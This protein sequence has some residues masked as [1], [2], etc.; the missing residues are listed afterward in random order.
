MIRDPRI[1]HR[2]VGTQSNGNWVTLVEALRSHARRNPQKIACACGDQ[3]ITYE[4]LDDASTRLAARLLGQGL[5]PGDRLAIHWPN[6]IETVQLFFAAFKAGLI[7]VPVNLRLKTAEIEF[8]LKHSGATLC[9]SHPALSA[10][11]QP[12]AAACGCLLRT[13][14]PDEQ[15]E[16]ATLPHVNVDA[17][18]IILYTSGTTARPK[19]VVHTHETLLACSSLSAQALNYVQDDIMVTVLPMMHAAALACVLFPAILVGA[20][21]V[22]IPSFDPAAILDAIER[23]RV[24]T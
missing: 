8:V 18:A 2:L 12:A 1:S 22:L 6:A 14:L 24:P 11:A 7:A 17:P 23:F 5:K 21:A 3:K 16:N 13:S 15:T 20:G 10:A 19:G 9:F 4:E